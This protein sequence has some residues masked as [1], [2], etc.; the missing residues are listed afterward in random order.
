MVCKRGLVGPLIHAAGG[1]SAIVRSPRATAAIKILGNKLKAAV[2]HHEWDVAELRADRGLAVEYLKAAMESIDNPNDRAGYPAGFFVL[3][4][5]GLTTFRLGKRRKSRSADQSS[6]TPCDR[7][8]AATL[9][10]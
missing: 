8:S 2:S 9:A 7:Q 1:L 3:A 5:N 4:P 10:S 6:R